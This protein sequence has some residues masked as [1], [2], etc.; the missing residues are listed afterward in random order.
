M[1]VRHCPARLRPSR[2][3]A[4]AAARR[5]GCP[6]GGPPVRDARSEPGSA[7]H[8]VRSRRRP[9]R[10]ARIAPTRPTSSRRT[11]RHSRRVLGRPRPHPRHLRD[12]RPHPRSPR[13]CHPSIRPHRN[14]GHAVTEYSPSVTLSADL[15]A[16]GWSRAGFH[17]RPGAGEPTADLATQ[18]RRHPR[19]AGAEHH[20]RGCRRWGRPVHRRSGRGGHDPQSALRRCDGDVHDDRQGQLRLP[21]DD[22]TT[23]RTGPGSRFGEGAR[24]YSE[25]FHG[26][27]LSLRRR[28]HVAGGCRGEN[29]VGTHWTCDAGQAA[30]DRQII[31]ADFLGRLCRPRCPLPRL[32]SKA[33]SPYAVRA[34]R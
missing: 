6:W 3:G 27:G 31:S 21:H 30:V 11:A 29:S 12:R 26:I 4:A 18:G 2:A 24:H 1:A 33:P 8:G 28:D 14:P 34:P 13:P 22:P 9:C 7:V 19:R 17:P 10:S 16:R 23:G 20:R 32:T 15:S 5:H 25:R